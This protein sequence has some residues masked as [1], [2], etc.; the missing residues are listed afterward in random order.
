MS[1]SANVAEA[2]S[3]E[4]LLAEGEKNGEVQD[5]PKRRGPK[6]RRF[7]KTQEMLIRYIAGE[8]ALDGGVRCTKQELADRFGRNVKTM[9]RCISALRRESVIQ[10][11]ANFDERGAQVS[12]LYRVESIANLLS[13]DNSGEL[14][15]PGDSD[16]RGASPADERI[17]GEDE[18]SPEKEQER[19][20]K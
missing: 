12:N 9:D 10:V 16:D 4:V 14:V 8:T 6:K 7:T 5:A 11:E 13:H 1:S 20:E 15:S 19:R 17:G 2:K 3:S 18:P